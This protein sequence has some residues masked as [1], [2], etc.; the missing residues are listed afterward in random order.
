[1]DVTL[2]I[3]YVN[4]PVLSLQILLAP[5][6]ISQDARVLTKFYSSFILLTE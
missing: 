1:M 2:I 4:V 3:F 6:M 5:P